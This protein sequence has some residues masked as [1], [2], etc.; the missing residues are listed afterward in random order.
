MWKVFCREIGE[1]MCKLTAR[2]CLEQLGSLGSIY[3]RPMTRHSGPPERPLKSSLGSC[4]GDNQSGTA[5]MPVK[6]YRLGQI[7]IP[8]ISTRQV[9]NHMNARRLYLIPP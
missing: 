2:H 9:Y 3:S 8:Y 1:I 6:S 4:A 5:T 7:I